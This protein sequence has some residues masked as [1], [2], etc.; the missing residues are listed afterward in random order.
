MGFYC[1]I[2]INKGLLKNLL[3]KT[4]MGWHGDFDT[5]TE[6]LHKQLLMCNIQISSLKLF[7]FLY[8]HRNLRLPEECL[9]VPSNLTCI[10][11][12]SLQGEP[13]RHLLTTGWSSFVNKKKLVS[14]DAVL[15]LRFFLSPYIFNPLAAI[16]VVS[17]NVMFGSGVRM[18]N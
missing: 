14:G 15:F 2:I 7:D 5:S 16:Q 13:C 11:H 1:R 18:E 10:F 17:C 8:W 6:V 3:Q 4:Y 9:F 12:F